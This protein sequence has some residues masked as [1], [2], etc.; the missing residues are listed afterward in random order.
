[1][2]F[3][4]VQDPDDDDGND[5]DSDREEGPKHAHA[6]SAAHAASSHAVH[7]EFGD[8]HEARRAERRF[9]QVGKRRAKARKEGRGEEPHGPSLA[10]SRAYKEE[11]QR[12]RF[13]VDHENA[14]SSLVLGGGLH[15]VH[16]HAQVVLPHFFV[17]A[18]SSIS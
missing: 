2:E 10:G 12:A 1:M 3:L 18:C 7:D 6:A 16:V 13:L 4:V 8:D 14:V 9:T 15:E 17:A 11:V 5:G